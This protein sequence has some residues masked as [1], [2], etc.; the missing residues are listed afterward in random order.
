MKN[1]NE[2]PENTVVVYVSGGVVQWTARGSGR[3]IDL[4]VIDHDDDSET[5]FATWFDPCHT[6]VEFDKEIGWAIDRAYKENK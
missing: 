1:S 2:L 4:L 3:R 6:N 5:R